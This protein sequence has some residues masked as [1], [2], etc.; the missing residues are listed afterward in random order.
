MFVN[1]IADDGSKID[2]DVHPSALMYLTDVNDRKHEFFLKSVAKHGGDG[3]GGHYTCGINLAFAW[4]I[5]DDAKNF[6]VF[7]NAP[8]DGCLLVYE[9][10]IEAMPM[11]S[12]LTTVE[13]KVLKYFIKCN[14]NGPALLSDFETASVDTTDVKG[15]LAIKNGK[16]DLPELSGKDF[17]PMTPP[18]TP[19][20]RIFNPISQYSAIAKK[21]VPNEVTPMTPDSMISTPGNPASVSPTHVSPTSV[22][23]NPENK[24]ESEQKSVVN[25]TYEMILA[26]NPNLHLRIDNMESLQPTPKKSESNTENID[27]NIEKLEKQFTDEKV[28]LGRVIQQLEN[29]QEKLLKD[30][31]HG[32]SFK[33]ELFEEVQNSDRENKEKIKILDSSLKHCEIKLGEQTSA[34]EACLRDL[35]DLQEVEREQQNLIRLQKDKIRRMEMEVKGMKEESKGGLTPLVKTKD[36]GLDEQEESGEDQEIKKGLKKMAELKTKMKSKTKAKT[37]TNTKMI[38]KTK[39]KTQTTTKTETTTTRALSSGIAIGKAAFRSLT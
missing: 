21:I 32:V 33:E 16:L 12:S 39:A 1:R 14:K 5:C 11:L 34:K 35:E 20:S 17:A 28:D 3:N 24:I 7:T 37:N 15:L 25:F 8:L 10:K 27:S 36:E 22:E 30:K 29:V 26:M 4:R 2:K 6:Q 18:M 13:Q 23:Q 19:Y 38:T 31:S 9:S